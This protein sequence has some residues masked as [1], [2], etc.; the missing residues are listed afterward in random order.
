[1][2][3]STIDTAHDLVRATDALAA[4]DARFAPICAKTGPL[5]LRRKPQ[6]FVTILD[7]I[8]SQQ[9]SVASARAIWARL[10][11]AGLTEEGAV[12]RANEGDLLAHGLSRP[13]ERYARAIAR[14]RFD[15]SGLRVMP[16]AEAAQAL[17][18]LPG[19]GRWTADIYLLSALGRPDVMPA[20][21][22]ALQEAA[23]LAFD[24]PQRPDA[25]Q[26]G[27]MAADWSPWR[28]VAARALWAYYR[29]EKSREGLR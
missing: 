23:R 22:L 5:P 15:W 27:A 12:A 20:G 1:M 9:I 17:M 16:D 24:L 4:L 10:D 26:F 14:Q 3:I 25:R 28:A 8:V 7:A 21:D 19:V 2:S 13:K 29:L 18:Q 11:R 6:G